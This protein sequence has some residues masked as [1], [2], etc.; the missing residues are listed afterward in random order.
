M[1]TAT[2]DPVLSLY[3]NDRIDDPFTGLGYFLNNNFHSIAT[4][5]D[6]ALA[7]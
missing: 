2:L 5:V 3:W 7:A 1:S 4:A 6:P